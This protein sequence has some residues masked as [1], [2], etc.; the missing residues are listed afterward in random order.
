MLVK[1][2]RMGGLGEVIEL[3]IVPIGFIIEYLTSAS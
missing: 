1:A 2:E 3:I